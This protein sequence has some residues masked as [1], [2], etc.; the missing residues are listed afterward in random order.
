MNDAESQFAS[1]LE[2]D[3]AH[4][5]GPGYAIDDLQLTIGDGWARVVATLRL[6]R[7]IETIDAVGRDALTLYRPLLQRAAE[8]RLAATFRQVI[9]RA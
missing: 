8:T 5:V 9:E 6:G 2:D 4:V 1:R 7:E 3:L